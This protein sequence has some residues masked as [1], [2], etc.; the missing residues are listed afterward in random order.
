MTIFDIPVRRL[1]ESFDI[2]DEVGLHELNGFVAVIQL[3]LKLCFLGSQVLVE[4]VGPH[5]QGDDEPIDNG[6]VGVGW[7]VVARDGTM[8]RSRGHLAEGEE[9]VGGGCGS[10]R[11][12]SS[13]SGSKESR[14]SGM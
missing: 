4:A 10:C 3:L 9:V 11:Y 13:G 7:E 5:F 12:W 1:G 14:L 6:S 8:D 2:P